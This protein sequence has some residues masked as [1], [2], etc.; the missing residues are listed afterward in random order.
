MSTTEFAFGFWIRGDCRQQRLVVDAGAAFAGYAGCDERCELTRESYLSEFQFAAEFRDHLR[1][2]GTTPHFGGGCWSPLL[3]LD[4][5]AE[6]RLPKALD[7]TRR[8][9]VLIGD[10]LGV[11]DEDVLAFF[12]GA[13]GFHVGIPRALWQPEP[14]R[15]LHRV[16][17]C[18]AKRLAETAGVTVDAGVYDRVRAFRARTR[19][20]RRPGGT[21]GVSR[22]KSC[23]ISSAATIIDRAA[24]PEPFEIPDPPP[25]QPG[26]ELAAVGRPRQK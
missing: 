23:Y 11:A 25:R 24:T 9:C 14:G 6:G 19:D 17:R 8:L 1:S 16:A 4:V 10:K 3:W 21:S 15:E 20:I 12:S 26:G 5:N 13:K 2:T 7:S 22:S 18:F